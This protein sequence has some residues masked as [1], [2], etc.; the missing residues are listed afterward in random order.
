MHT[1]LADG[2][3][4]FPYKFRLFSCDQKLTRTP[5]PFSLERK[6]RTFTFLVLSMVL[7]ESQTSPFSHGNMQ[8]GFQMALHIPGSKFRHLLPLCHRLHVLVQQD[9]SPV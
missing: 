1:C 7:E 3:G 5:P 2:L 9:T 4:R 6:M 8:N